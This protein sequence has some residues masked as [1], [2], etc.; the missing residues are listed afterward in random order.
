MPSPPTSRHRRPSRQKRASPR[1]AGP[2]CSRFCWCWGLI[3]GAVGWSRWISTLPDTSNLL[4][5]GPSHD[6][7]ILDTR[8]RLIARRG[9][10][11]GAMVPVSALPAYV[12]DAFIA[13]EDRRFRSHFGLDP[14]GMARAAFENLVAGHVVQGGSTITQQLAKNLFL[15]PKRTFDRKMQEALL[16]LYLESRYSKDEIL[17]LYLN[18]V[19][20]GAGAYGIEAAAERFFGKPA[21]RLTLTEAAMLA[22]SVRAPANYNPLSDPDASMARAGLVLAAM[23]DCGF[24]TAENARLAKATRPR[25][26]RR[27]G[28]PGSGYFADW[29]EGQLPG[30]I[31]EVAGPVIVHTTFDLVFQA[32]AE[33]AVS[34]GLAQEGAQIR[35]PSGGARGDDAGRRS[36]R[37]GGRP[38]LRAKPVQPRHRRAAPA[39]FG[40]QALRLSDR[41][42]ARPQTGRRDGG[43]AGRHPRL[44]AHRLRRPLRRPDDADGRLREILQ[45]HRRQAHGRGRPR[46][47][48]QDRAPARHHHTLGRRAGDRARHLL[49]DAA[50]T[51]RRLCELR[52][53]RQRRGA[54]RHHGSHDSFGQGALCAQE[55][56][57]R[58]GDAARGQCGRSPN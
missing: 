54:L 46:R 55:L 4:A 20:F 17:T 27:N 43:R 2:M 3:F 50:R 56:R 49:G 53:W 40:L 36:R 24:I 5:K 16:A 6:I 45:R 32:E 34:Q 10:T 35:R 21:A 30:F 47:R 25:V 12:P 22:G 13:I 7:T 26:V 1:E 51:D 11:R 41:L 57:P 29:V 44:E 15:D 48:R 28:T 39:R 8:G 18:R 23:T 42:R 33:R 19:Y 37:D 14:I 38:L 58:P 9:L 52:Q 31:G